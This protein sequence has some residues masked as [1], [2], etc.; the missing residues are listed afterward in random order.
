[1]KQKLKIYA[2]TLMALILSSVGWAASDDTLLVLSTRGLDHYAD[3]TAVQSGEMYALVWM[4]SGCDFAGFDLTGNPRR[5]VAAATAHHGHSGRE[6]L[7]ST[8]SEGDER[9]R[10][11]QCR[12]VG[13]AGGARG[14]RR[15]RTYAVP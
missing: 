5:R 7:G 12:L 6:W 13:R 3:G 15:L 9:N 14:R 11:H 2:W 8:D 1:M 10:L 4:R